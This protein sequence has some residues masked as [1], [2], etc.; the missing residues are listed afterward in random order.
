MSVAE[1]PKPA[2][3]IKA[4][5][6][7]LHDHPD[8]TGQVPCSWCQITVQQARGWGAWDNDKRG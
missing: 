2:W 7:C 5:E 8:W 3:L 6:L 1:L 4:A